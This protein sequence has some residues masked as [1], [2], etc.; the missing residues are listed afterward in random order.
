MLG[1]LMLEGYETY[2]VADWDCEGAAPI[3][4]A[5][6]AMARRLLA[7]LAPLGAPDDA[8]GADGTICL[9]WRFPDGREFWLDIGP[10]PTD[11]GGYIPKRVLSAR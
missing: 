6:L 4:P 7:M 8:P 11:I 2:A 5:V 3:S 9:E 10:K 1:F